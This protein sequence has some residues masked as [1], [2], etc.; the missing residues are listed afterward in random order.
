MK[1]FSVQTASTTFKEKVLPSSLDELQ[2][3]TEKPS[4]FHQRHL[5]RGSFHLMLLPN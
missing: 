5:Q 4:F 3:S 1:S 2:F